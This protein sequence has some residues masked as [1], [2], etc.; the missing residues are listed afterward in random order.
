M[1]HRCGTRYVVD[2]PVY[3]RTRNAALSSAGRLCEISITGGFVET[4]MP[5]PPLSYIAIQVVTDEKLPRELLFLEGQVVRRDPQGLGIEWNEYAPRLVQHLT[6][7]AR[8]S[9]AGAASVDPLL[10]WEA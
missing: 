3:V 9:R 5:A 2:V 1:E 7:S 4:V 10:K 8:A 6:E